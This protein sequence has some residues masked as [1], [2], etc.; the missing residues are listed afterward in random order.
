MLGT[1][2]V[3]LPVVLPGTLRAVY[4]APLII[5]LR[6]IR[7]GRAVPTP[8]QARQRWVRQKGRKVRVSVEAILMIGGTVEVSTGLLCRVSQGLAIRFAVG[9]QCTTYICTG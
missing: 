5:I 6:T 1:A 3:G 4:Y 2:V 7:L 9:E 8:P